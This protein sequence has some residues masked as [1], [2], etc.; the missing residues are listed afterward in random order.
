MLASPDP[1]PEIPRWTRIPF[2]YTADDG[3]AYLEATCSLSSR[4]ISP[5]VS[6]DLRPPTTSYPTIRLE[7]AGF[8]ALYA[9]GSA[10][11]AEHVE[12]ALAGR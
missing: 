12:E 8:P 11:V 2:P 10:A 3:R 5:R 1:P 9:G 7:A 6:G 4:R